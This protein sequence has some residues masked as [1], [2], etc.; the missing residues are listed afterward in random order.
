MMPATA[1]FPKATD[2]SSKTNLKENYYTHTIIQHFHSFFSLL[3]FP[4]SSYSSVFT[5]SSSSSFL[6]ANLVSSLSIVKPAN[7]LNS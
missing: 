1:T 7:S 6:L 3:L 2:K 4:L 5:F